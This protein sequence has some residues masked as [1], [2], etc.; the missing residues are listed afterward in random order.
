M[1]K[2]TKTLQRHIEKFDNRKQNKKFNVPPLMEFIEA[3]EMYIGDV[4]YTMDVFESSVLFKVKGKAYIVETYEGL[5]AQL[6]S[7]VEGTSYE[8]LF[9]QTDSSIWSMI[10]GDPGIEKSQF[11]PAI[12]NRWEEFWDGQEREFKGEHIAKLKEKSWRKL[13][14]FINTYDSANPIDLA[15]EIDDLEFIPLAVLAMLDCYDRNE[16][17]YE[18]CEFHLEGSEYESIAPN[19]FRVHAADPDSTED[20]EYNIFYIRHAQEYEA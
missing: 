15:E 18:Y 1:Q 16:C 17:Y 7:Y 11:I 14:V 20:I 9:T 3:F 10:C 12:L 6:D 19:E 13:Q 2:V 8:E 5:S 4:K